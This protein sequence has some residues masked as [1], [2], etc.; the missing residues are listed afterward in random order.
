[1]TDQQRS[2]VSKPIDWAWHRI[3]GDGVGFH[4]LKD[5][6]AMWVLLIAM[7]VVLA[8]MTA[9]IWGAILVWELTHA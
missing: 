2:L 6:V 7:A 9:P 3:T 5:T 4:L 8:V 1:M